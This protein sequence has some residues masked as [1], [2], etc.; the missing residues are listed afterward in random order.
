MCLRAGQRPRVTSEAG[1]PQRD[2]RS[3]ALGKDYEAPQTTLPVSHGT[4]QLQ[5]QPSDKTKPQPGELRSTISTKVEQ[6]AG[7]TH[8]TQTSEGEGEGL[9]RAKEKNTAVVSVIA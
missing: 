2:P 4:V 7:A 3:I 8:P 1:G 5:R 6:S 9:R